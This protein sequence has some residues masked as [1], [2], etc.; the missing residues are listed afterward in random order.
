[1]LVAALLV[2]LLVPAP[3]GVELWPLTRWRLFSLARDDDQTRW[4]LE[5]VDDGGARRI[6]SLEALPLGYRHAE[7]PMAELP[8]SS[9]ARRDAV[10]GA[11]VEAVVEVAPA[12]VELAIARDH[13]RLVEDE[14]TWTTEHEIDVF[15]T[16]TIDRGAGTSRGGTGG[17]TG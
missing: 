12:T 15:H 1:M 2:L 9:R 3:I 6:V 8:G 10:C 7:W 5:A 17:G 4:V 13:S 16:C 11:L 14:G